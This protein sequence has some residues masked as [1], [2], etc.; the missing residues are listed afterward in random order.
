[1]YGVK[2]PGTALSASRTGRPNYL[3]TVLG[4]EDKRRCG[5]LAVVRSTSRGWFF[6]PVG[7]DGFNLPPWFA[8]LCCVWFTTDRVLVLVLVRSTDNWLSALMRRCEG[9]DAVEDAAL[10]RGGGATAQGLARHCDAVIGGWRGRRGGDWRGHGYI[11]RDEVALAGGRAARDFTVNSR[12]LSRYLVR[13]APPSAHRS[14]PDVLARQGT[15]R[16]CPVVSAGPLD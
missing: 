9:G 8:L 16:F 11:V 14:T 12:Y 7:W 1:M 5:A 10:R 13:P 4:R 6:W 3:G 2:V 15:C